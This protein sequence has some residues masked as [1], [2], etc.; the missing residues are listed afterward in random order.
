MY[1]DILV[2]FVF[3][4]ATYVGEETAANFFNILSTDDNGV[5]HNGAVKMII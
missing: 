2:S 1:G 3:L 4:L 5:I